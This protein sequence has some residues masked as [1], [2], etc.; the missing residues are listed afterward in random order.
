M[1]EI[2]EIRDAMR[3]RKKART[4]RRIAIVII[5]AALVVAVIINKDRLSPEAI[6]NWLSG[7]LSQGSG[8][9]GFPVELPSGETVD[10]SGAGN[11]VVLTNQTN[12]YFYSSR[13]KQ[14][15]NVQ[16]ARKNVQSKVAGENV[17]VYAVGGN[18]VSVE[19]SS[20]TAAALETDN[21]IITGEIAKNGRF[22]IATKS[23]VYTSEMKVYDKNANAVFKWTPS[24]GVI[25][26]LSLSQDGN[27]V[28]AA[29]VYTQGG[30]IMSGIYLFATSKS[31]ALFSY[32]LENELVLSLTCE[33]KSVLAVSDARLLELDMAGEVT[34]NF[35]FDGKQLIDSAVCSKGLAM[36]FRDVNDPSRSVLYVIGNEGAVKSEAA[37]AHQVIDMA[38]SGDDI[39]LLTET[40]ILRYQASTAIKNGECEIEDDAEWLCANSAGAY[41]ITA[42]SQMLRPDIG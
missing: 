15:R 25:T 38:C 17:L 4:V 33:K 1:A 27:Y 5:L 11:N 18:E 3:R 32:Q 42:A 34:G 40:A 31:E 35:S 24:G 30:K 26:A 6:S 21:T 19:T 29:T 41:V 2:K 36:V 23:D 14:L 9:E 37:V 20:K 39:Y 8:E 13:G 28:A 10:V 7:S 12:L 22:A 16:H